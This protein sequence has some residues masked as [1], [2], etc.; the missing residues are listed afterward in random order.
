MW[1]NGLLGSVYTFRAMMLRTVGVQV[2]ACECTSETLAPWFQ[3][4][5]MSGR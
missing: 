5:R 1:N 4:G 2:A 3:A